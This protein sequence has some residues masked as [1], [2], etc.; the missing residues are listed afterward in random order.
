MTRTELVKREDL[1]KT[2][3]LSEIVLLVSGVAVMV[4]FGMVV[5]A[6]FASAAVA[7]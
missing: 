6:A 7:Q 5:V 2:D 3:L 4:A 1:M